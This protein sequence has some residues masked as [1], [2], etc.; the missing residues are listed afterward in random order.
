V[1]SRASSRDSW[2]ELSSA[3]QSW[4]FL[5]QLQ[6]ARYQRAGQIETSPL[7]AYCRKRTTARYGLDNRAADRQTHPM[8][9]DFV[10]KSGLNIRPVSCAARVLV[11]GTS[12]GNDRDQQG[13]RGERRSDPGQLIVRQTV[14]QPNVPNPSACRIAEI[15]STLIQRRGE[16]GRLAASFTTRICNG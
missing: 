12:I 8:P 9:S 6:T 14:R 3:S 5:K 7:A 11:L 16:T 1:I 2:L 15:E 13:D 4:G 10:V